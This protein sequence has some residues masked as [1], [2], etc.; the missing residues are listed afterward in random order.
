MIGNVLG[1]RSVMTTPQRSR[2]ALSLLR[3]K[4]RSVAPEA[5]PVGMR[6][7]FTESCIMRDCKGAQSSQKAVSIP[8]VSRKT[9]F[10]IGEEI[11]IN[12]V[13]HSEFADAGVG[14]GDTNGFGLCFVSSAD[15]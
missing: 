3:S 9:H 11:V 2:T 4:S 13:G 15:G 12:K 14:K 10:G 7:S 6:A 1:L 5:V 8:A